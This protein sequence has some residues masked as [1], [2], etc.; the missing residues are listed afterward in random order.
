M[1]SKNA[2][3]RIGLIGRISIA[4][5][6]EPISKLLAF[7]LAHG[8]EVVVDNETA[9]LLN[10]NKHKIADKHDLAK[11][12]DLIIVVGGDGSL[13]NAAHFAAPCN[14][15]V[16]GVNRGT[17]GFLT[18]INP[19]NLEPIAEILNG[20]YIEEKR[21]MLQ[22]H[23]PVDPAA[24]EI[25]SALNDVV[26]LPG[27][28]T[29]MI[30]FEVLINEQFVYSLRAD[31]LIIATPTGS[32]AYALSGGG[33]IIHPKVNAMVLVPMSPHTLSSRPIVVDAESK[34]EIIISEENPCAPHLSCDGQ[35]QLLVEPGSKI[36]INK[37]EDQLRLIHLN[38]YTYY[39]TLRTKLH[40]KG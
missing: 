21:F 36:S 15:P 18:D 33:P 28:K 19:D 35:Q 9:S 29:R 12:V 1:T 38:T 16:L 7:L 37:S 11:Q 26:L 32:T 24:K 39:E 22:A 13:L 6:E 2:F 25:V 14:V 8:C 23:V 20:Q 10:T 5:I 40:W 34:I 17:L 3:R 31:G 30:K 4:G 27:E